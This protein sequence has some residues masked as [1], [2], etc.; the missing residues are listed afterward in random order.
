VPLDEEQTPLTFYI[1]IY[2]FICIYLY[3]YV[4]IYNSVNVGLSTTALVTDSR[5]Y[6][7]DIFPKRRARSKDFL[8]VVTA[9]PAHE[10]IEIN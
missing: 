8:T 7:T 1:Y 4:Y 5:R 10:Q 2:L 3:I 9:T 6:D